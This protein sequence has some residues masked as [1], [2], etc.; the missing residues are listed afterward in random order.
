VLVDAARLSVYGA[1]FIGHHLQ[2]SAGIISTVVVAIGCAF[3]GALIGKQLL[4]KVTLR[5]V[6]LV[7]AATMFVVGAALSAGLPQ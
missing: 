6:R 5:I 2:R 7:V 1:S 4:Q 3:A